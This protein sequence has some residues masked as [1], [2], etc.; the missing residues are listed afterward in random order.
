MQ[1]NEEQITFFAKT[2]FRN[3][4]VPF[5]IK[6]DDRRRHMYII[7][8]TGMGK[9]TLMENMAIQDI[10]NGHG[11]CF[12]DA[13]GDSVAKIL[14]FV[15]PS[16]VNDVIYFNPADQEF[17]I[18][19]NV[20]ESVGPQ[21]KHLVADGLMG[22]FT[23]IWANM[24]SSRMEYIL[25]N[26]VRAL[27]D[28]P[29]TTILG[30]TRMYLD[31]AYRKR[32]VDNIQDPMVKLFWTEEYANYDQKYVKEAVAPIQNKVGQFLSS[33]IIRN[34]VGQPKSTIDIRKI[35]DERKVLLVDI[36][37][38]KVGEDNS[39]LLGAMLVTK[40]QM[41]ALS[42][43]DIPNEADRSDFYLYVDEFQNFATESFATIL[44]EARK[45]HLNLI[46]G[47]QYIGQLTPEKSN[48]RLRDAIFGNVGSIVCFR[49]GAADAEFLATEFAPI[50]TPNDLV[51]LPKWEIILKLM[52]NGIAS[53][54]FSAQSIPV[55]P[56]F[57]TGNAEKVIRVSRE[58]FANSK[59]VVEDKISRWMGAE[60]SPT[61]TPSEPTLTKQDPTFVAESDDFKVAEAKQTN[62]PEFKPLLTNLDLVYSGP[63]THV[64]K[65]VFDNP[66]APISNRNEASAFK[67]SPPK[68][69]G[70]AQQKFTTVNAGVKK[71]KKKKKRS[72]QN[73]NASQN[74][75]VWDKIHGAGPSNTLVDTPTN[76]GNLEDLLT[77]GIEEAFAGT[78]SAQT[79]L[80]NTLNTSPKPPGNAST[81]AKD[82][83]E[84]PE[85]L[86]GKSLDPGQTQFL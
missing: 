41:A 84:P 10:R 22:V 35:M 44:S 31:K 21:F 81:Q 70:F 34:I 24:W 45:Y 54:P 62:V 12:I 56:S 38:G 40:L 73:S 11:V 63:A 39:A 47:H 80:D 66:P 23:K 18:A 75:S 42:R 3:R 37:K 83:E 17:P 1:D 7:G 2:N 32:I 25:S 46:M 60:P 9:T 43:A 26:T 65:Q 78:K 27:L 51:N 16:R 68:Q 71:N 6:T 8:K 58:R 55:N 5:G 15:P 85:S 69:D 48:T 59:D 76:T 67:A 36:S 52:I 74:T 57:R 13:H 79:V 20:M 30:I 19:F 14:D 49:V 86:P 72:S 82:L 4:E 50:Y 53:E 64:D 33:S 77:K 61:Q 28:N 29:G